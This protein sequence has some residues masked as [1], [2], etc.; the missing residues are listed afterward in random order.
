[1]DKLFFLKKFAFENSQVMEDKDNL[2]GSLEQDL[3]KLKKRLKSEKEALSKVLNS[4]KNNSLVSAENLKIEIRSDSNEEQGKEPFQDNLHEEI[5]H[6][7][8]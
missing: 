3:K 8:T 5:V 7:K 6:K 2:Q 4:L 1:L